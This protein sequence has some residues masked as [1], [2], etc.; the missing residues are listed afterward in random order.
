MIGISC[1]EPDRDGGYSF[2]VTYEADDDPRPL[3]PPE[4]GA[5][6]DRPDGVD[7]CGLG[8]GGGG[9]SGGAAG[10]EDDEFPDPAGD[11][12]ALHGTATVPCEI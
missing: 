2:A 6:E 9:G 4:L 1:S 8:G 11:P 3:P 7:K 10:D 5:A 12:A